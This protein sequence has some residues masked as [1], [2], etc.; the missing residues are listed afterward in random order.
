MLTRTD[1]GCVAVYQATAGTARC[2]YGKGG[3][4]GAASTAD[5]ATTTRAVSGA[6]GGFHG[7]NGDDAAAAPAAVF[8]GRHDSLATDLLAGTAAPAIAGHGNSQPDWLL[9]TAFRV[10][11]TAVATATFHVLGT[12]NTIFQWCHRLFE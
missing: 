7:G 8:H 3:F 11:R 12:R 2:D 6:D 9:A 10:D 1:T 5:A 4:Y